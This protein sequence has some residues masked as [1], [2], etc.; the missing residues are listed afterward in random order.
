MAA[1]RACIALMDSGVAHVERHGYQGQWRSHICWIAGCER[2]QVKFLSPHLLDRFAL[3]LAGEDMRSGSRVTDLREWLIA[4][5]EPE[6]V[7]HCWRTPKVVK[8]R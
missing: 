1:A 7:G 5:Y 2:S 3:R 8:S 4:L 6:S